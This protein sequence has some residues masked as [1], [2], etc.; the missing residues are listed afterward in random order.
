MKK[1]TG[2]KA[3]IA[4]VMPKLGRYG[5]AEGFAWRLAAALAD[6]GFAV[7]YICA[8]IEEEPPLG[9]HP[10]VVGRFGPFRFIKILWF[11]IAADWVQRRNNYDLVIGLGNTVNQDIA[12]VGGCPIR[13]FNRLSIRAW[14]KGFPRFFKAFRRAVAPAGL[15]IAAIDALRMKR[16]RTV[17]AVSDF[18]R[19]RIVEAHPGLNADKIQVI[20][21]E[22]D[23]SRFSPPSTR[24][25]ASCRKMFGIQNSDV[26]I[27]TAGTNFILKGIASLI[28]ALS[29]LPPE[30]KLH[31][32][33]GRNAVGYMRLARRLGVEDRVCFHGRVTDMS[34]FYK[35]ADVFVLASFFDACSNAVLE[36]QASG[37]RVLS[38]AMNGSSRFLNPEH[39]FSNP[40]DHEMIASMIKRVCGLPVA[41]A[42]AWS[43]A[44]KMGLDPYFDLVE[45]KINAKQ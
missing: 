45:Q 10:V 32:A 16:A 31:I 7:D 22:P 12:R 17:V 38:S 11:A 39:V 5:G 30:F 26:V 1:N 40:A 44:L 33:G 41:V 13:V 24:E 18:V 34:S 37:C 35:A 6:K 20:Y 36:A 21:N 2:E 9:V 27:A 15:T 43:P 23:V 19:D 4:V 14:P 8:R 28:R 42:P 29:L 3:H 25:R